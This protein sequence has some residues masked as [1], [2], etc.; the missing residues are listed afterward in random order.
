MVLFQLFGLKYLS[1]RLSPFRDC[2]LCK[3]LQ[4]IFKA[5]RDLTPIMFLLCSNF[6][7]NNAMFGR[8]FFYFFFLFFEEVG[9]EPSLLCGVLMEMLF[10]LKIEKC[11]SRGVKNEEYCSTSSPL[12][13][14]MLCDV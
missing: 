5:L 13:Y 10:V 9:G 6:T 7:R 8:I 12:C 3:I 4:K 2:P 1:S 11:L 14:I